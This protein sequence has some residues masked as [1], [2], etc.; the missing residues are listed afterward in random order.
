[1][2]VVYLQ[3]AYTL[4]DLPDCDDHFGARLIEFDDSDISLSCLDLLK[5]LSLEFTSKYPIW[6]SRIHY[7]HCMYKRQY[8]YVVSQMIWLSLTIACMKIHREL[9]YTSC[10]KVYKIEIFFGFDFEICIISLLVM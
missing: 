7:M 6:D 1:M 8:E 2:C 5:G 3:Q 4:L 9:L 10:L